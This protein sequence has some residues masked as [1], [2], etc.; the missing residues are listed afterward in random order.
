MSLFVGKDLA[1]ELCDI[2]RTESALD[3]I[4]SNLASTNRELMK[5]SARLLEQSL[6]TSNRYVCLF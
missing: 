2:L 4:V 1:Y 6:T 3:I 5:V